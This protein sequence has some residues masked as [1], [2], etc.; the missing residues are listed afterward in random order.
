MARIA[1]GEHSARS[2]GTIN[3]IGVT[4]RSIVPFI[5]MAVFGYLAFW[6]RKSSAKVS[7]TLSLVCAAVFLVFL[8]LNPDPRGRYVDAFFVMMGLGIGFR[9]LNG[10][11]L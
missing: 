4:M 10:E 9:R 8:L 2:T 1:G 3:P 11:K 6:T 5:L 7:G